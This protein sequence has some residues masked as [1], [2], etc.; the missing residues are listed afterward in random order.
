MASIS[1]PVKEQRLDNGLRV[2]V[3]EDHGVPTVAV[4]LWYAVGSRN[5]VA[6]RTGFAHL[7]EHLMFQGSRNVGPTEHFAILQEYG[8]SLNATTSFDRTNYYETLPA[9]ALELALWLESDR[10]GTLLDA[11]TQENFDNQRDVVKEEKRQRYDNVPYGSSSERLFRLTFPEGHPYAHLPIGSMADLDAAT[12]EDAHAFFRTHY[13]PGNAVLTIVG[14]VDAAEAF[15]L[16]ER[17]F[18]RVPA[19]AAPPPARD[20]SIGPL[21]AT[22]REEVVDQVPNDAAY[23]VFR[24]PAEGSDEIEAADL[25]LAILADGATSRL[26]RRLVRRDEIAQTVG[27]YANRLIGGASTGHL[28]A[29]ASSGVEL[30]RVEDVLVEELERFATDGPTD[31]EVETAK[32]QAERS[33]LESLATCRGRADGLSRSATLFGDPAQL[34]EQLDRLQA[35]T[36]ERIHALARDRLR[37]HQRVVV[38]FRSDAEAGEGTEA[39]EGV[40]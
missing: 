24:L 5:E 31:F 40:A 35:V 29:H 30:A 28:I 36:P 19:T 10:M 6:G 37:E 26:Y 18:G 12:L 14:D 16:A 2:V 25:A 20:G 3:S 7:F 4:N 13:G 11:L 22:V 21:T 23:F 39:E 34:M 27:G 38:T 8:A 32:A 33:W 1:Y 17:Q 9:G 15:R